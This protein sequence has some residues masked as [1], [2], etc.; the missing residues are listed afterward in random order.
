VTT[1]PD[2]RICAV[3]PTLDNPRTVGTTVRGIRDH[4]LPVILVDD[5]SGP[6]GAAACAALERE[7]LVTLVRRARNGGKGAAVKDGFERAAEAGFTHVFQIDGDGQHDLSAIPRFLAAATASQNA[8]VL[9]MPAYAHDAPRSRTF[10]RGLMAFWVGL[11][12]GDSALVRDAMIGFRVYPL[13]AA[14]AVRR[15]GDRMEFDIEILVRMVR[16]GTPVVNL[17]V[18]VRYLTAEEGGVSHFRMVRDNARFSWMHCRLCTEGILG[19]I[20]SKFGMRS[21]SERGVA[22]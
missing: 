12:V 6:E 5:G 18:A 3:V 8:L 2:F 11:E 14:R 7:G 4:G 13:V 17:P 20:G 22:R 16:R 1:D 19:W 21:D 10:A 9:G 15:T